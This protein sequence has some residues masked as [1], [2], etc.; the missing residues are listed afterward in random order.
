MSDKHL[1][2]TPRFAKWIAS[3]LLNNSYTE[4]F[5]GDLQEMYDER[6]ETKSTF[7]ANMLYWID[8]W[9]LIFGFSS[10]HIFKF[11]QTMLL[12]NMFKIAWRNAIRQK[13]FT[14]LNLLGLTFGISVTLFIA[15]FIH[16]ELTYD[17]F[18]EH[19]DRI[20]RVNQPNI[21]GDWDEQISSTGP[22]VAIALREDAPEFE[23]VTRILDMG[24]Q[25]VKY[26]QGS[27]SNSFKEDAYYLVEENFFEVFSFEYIQGDP[28]TALSG[29]NQM[30][31]TR[32]T[33]ERYFGYADPIGK[34]VDVK[35]FEGVWQS[36]EITGVLENVPDKSH[37]QFDILVSFQSEQKFISQN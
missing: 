9:H 35:D 4:E 21:W 16:D 33:S 12:R 11:H 3:K 2:N 8:V 34:I 36:Y 23:E 27:E 22:N 6:L 20:Y 1:N 28:T 26:T 37:L 19:K 32:E 30:V 31:M 13:Q 5:L 24:N 10:I 15:L 18:H 14:V 17:T 25:I 29:P 7:R